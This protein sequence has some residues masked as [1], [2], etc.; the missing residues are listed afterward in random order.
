[1]NVTAVEKTLNPLSPSKV[2]STEDMRKVAMQF[3]AL[4]LQQLTSALN[5]TSEADPE[6]GE[7]NLFGGD[8]GTGLAKQMFSEQLATTMSQS[9]GV[10][11]ADV[12]FQKFGGKTDQP[13]PGKMNGLNDAILVMNDLKRPGTKTAGYE[14][15]ISPPKAAAGQNLFT[16]R[17]FKGNPDDAEIVS[18]FDDQLRAEG[19][20]PVTLVTFTA[21]SAPLDTRN[22]MV[23]ATAKSVP[24][25]VSA[26]AFR[27]PVRSGVSSGF[28]NRFHPIDKKIKFHAGLDLP[29]PVG[30][31]VKA[32]SEGVV[33]FAGWEGGYGNLVVIQHADCRETR[34]GHLQKLM[35]AADDK[36]STGQ[37]I[38]LSGSTGKST[39][40]H[41]HFEVRENGKAIDPF[42][43]LTKGLPY[44]A[45][46]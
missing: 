40:P 20:D 6:D 15:H 44:N 29:V 31:S 34:D 37:E 25:M 36:V 45:E 1:M 9:G 23:S 8:G 13:T 17:G 28:G 19:V 11:L 41:V 5:K 21:P 18:T 16:G 10:G 30:T 27:L 4:L 24:A 2:P 32:A 3:E 35:V 33:T 39:G 26:G 14:V 42:K 12:I 38:A 7:E 46:R 22:V 43:V